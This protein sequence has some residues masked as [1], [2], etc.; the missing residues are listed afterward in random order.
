MHASPHILANQ[1][2]ALCLAPAAFGGLESSVLRLSQGLWANGVDVR[3][4]LSIDAGAN[5]SVEAAARKSGIP[6]ERLEQPARAYVREFTE[7]RRRFRREGI[8]VVHTHGYRADLIAGMAARSLGIPVVTTFH[9]FTGGGRRNRTYER[10]QRMAATR[11]AA[12]IAVSD[13]IARDLTAFGVPS[14]R[15]VH[16]PNAFAPSD[17]A[18]SRAEARLTLGISS[19]A[20][21]IGWV[22]RL[23]YEKGPDIFVEAL[24]QLPSEERAVEAVVIG[25]GPMRNE[26]EALARDTGKAV[27]V[28]CVG[29]LPNAGALISA[30]DLLV[31]SSRT[32]GTPVTILEAMAA[33]VPV[34]AFDVGGIPELLGARDGYL[35]SDRTPKALATAVRDALSDP[36]GRAQRATKARQ[37]LAEHF[38]TAKWIA[39][40]TAI[41]ALVTVD[42][43][44]GPR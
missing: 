37:R 28:R 41:Y 31:L 9:G 42:E 38:D 40:H 25:D 18:L 34:V 4:M 2:I 33:E 32:E 29:Y 44:P 30:L 8:T 26:I 19:S 16:Q 13:V 5:S 3:L 39:R 1:R 11:A 14:A 24:S 23:S 6:V 43:A 10:L 17:D 27:Q 35:V 7:Y 22:G 36:R 15:L 20:L 21:A 12:V